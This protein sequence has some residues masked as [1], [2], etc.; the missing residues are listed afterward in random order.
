MKAEIIINKNFVIDRI[1]KRIYGSFL[2]HVGRAVYGGIYEP[3]HSSANKDGFREDV[4]ELVR[5]L[6]VPVIRYPGGNF[7]SGYNWEDGTG[8]KSKRPK[9]Q[10]LA[11]R[12]IETNQVGIDEFQKWTKQA[13]SGII[14]AVNVGTR[15]PVD[16]KNLVEYCNGETDTY[17]A[18]MRR[19][20]GFEKP[21]NI[22]TWCIGN[23]MDGAWQIGHKTADEYGRIAEETGKLMKLVD[24]DIELV[25]CGSSDYNISTFG[26]WEYTVLD[27]AYD[28]V[29]YISLHQYYKKSDT[30]DFLGNTVHMD[31]FIKSVAAIC[32]A[33]K[34]KK[35]S[36]KTINLSF[37]EWNVWHSNGCPMFD[38]EI[39]PHLYEDVYSFEDALLVGS[40]LITLQ[41]NCDRVKIA[42]LAQL[43]NVIAPIMTEDNGDAWVQTTFYPFMYSSAFGRG[44]TLKTVTKCE[45]YDTSEGVAVPY[46]DTSVINN[47][48][49]RELIVFAVN[50]SLD[51]DIET[52]FSLGEFEDAV[53]K[54]H[55]ILYSDNLKST[56]TKEKAEVVPENLAV[57]KV[58]GEKQTVTLKKHSWNMLRFDY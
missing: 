18:N 48:E 11:W 21:F 28:V 56:N 42:C 9:K 57:N 44:T 12:T 55:I 24:P 35:H 15:G 50:R 20:N 29:D 25:A 39:A 7:V 38:W 3:T 2:E 6:N 30:K 23:E 52:D 37:D 4:L 22:K 43:V 58:K 31:S 26:Q 19:E 5:K 40:M 53:L 54:E 46:I 32:D 33:V 27:H 10:D 16:A 41:N 8:D 36:S 17:Y 51:C 45:T 13:D 34:A 14:M 49:T 47:E 1:D